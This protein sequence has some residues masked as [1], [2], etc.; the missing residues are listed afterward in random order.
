MTFGLWWTKLKWIMKLSMLYK[1]IPLI[2][3]EVTQGHSISHQGALGNNLSVIPRLTPLHLLR[4]RLFRGIRV[5]VWV[6]VCIKTKLFPQRWYIALIYTS[7]KNKN[8]NCSINVTKST[9]NSHGIDMSKAYRTFL[10]KLRT[11][12]LLTNKYQYCQDKGT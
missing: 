12:I 3:W 1:S 11:N 5:I 10:N 7:I 4:K 6:Y 9:V 8:K 2:Y